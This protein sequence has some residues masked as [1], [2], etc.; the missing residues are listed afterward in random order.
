MEPLVILT[1]G[2][3]GATVLHP[4][5]CNCM[6]R[7]CRCKQQRWR[8]HRKASRERIQQRKTKIKRTIKKKFPERVADDICLA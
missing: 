3:W 4:D 8:R 6:K 5:G 1:N 2:K 7:P